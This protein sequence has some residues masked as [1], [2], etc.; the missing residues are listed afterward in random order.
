VSN[1]KPAIDVIHEVESLLA[2]PRF[3][4]RW[5]RH[6]Q[7]F[8]ERKSLIDLYIG[9]VLLIALAPV[10]FLLWL[11]VKISSRGPGFYRQTRVGLN[12]REFVLYK[13]RTMRQDAEKAGQ[14]V[15]CGKHDPRITRLGRIFRKLHL[16]EF[17]QIYNVARGEM[18]LV[19]PRPERPMICE[20]L[21]LEVDGYFERVMV[22]PGI[23]GLSQINLPPDE[24]LA[25][26]RRKQTLD[27]LY[28]NETNLW[29]EIRILFATFIRVVGIRGE[30]A[31]QAMSLCRRSV[32]AEMGLTNTPKPVVPEIS[33]SRAA[34]TNDVEPFFHSAFKTEG[35]IDLD[36]E[37]EAL[38]SPSGIGLHVS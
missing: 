5:T 26:V 27:L 21:A 37:C 6:R 7:T 18:L 10:I 20:E 14:P 24:S 29:F 28:I 19:G 11:V 30:A 15:W 2:P 31:M 34:V 25:D 32:L 33:K 22:K 12:G 9:R 16:D 4:V 13:L 38:E 3:S 1:I 35:E 17:P 8:F 36:E 23:T